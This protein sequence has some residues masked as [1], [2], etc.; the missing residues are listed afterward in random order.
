MKKVRFLHKHEDYEGNSVHELP[1]D[2]AEQLEQDGH[3][4]PEP[5]HGKGVQVHK[6]AKPPGLTPAEAAVPE[7]PAPPAPPK[8]EPARVPAEVVPA[9]PEK[10]FDKAKTLPKGRK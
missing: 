3:C 5:E 4:I 8:E 2:Q 9:A 7:F 10:D 6:A 1:E